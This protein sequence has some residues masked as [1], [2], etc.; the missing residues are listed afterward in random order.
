[1]PYRRG[2]NWMAQI[3]IDGQKLRKTFKTKAEALAWEVHQKEDTGVLLQQSR[4]AKKIV[5]VSLAEWATKYLDFAEVKFSF[6]TYDEKRRVFRLLFKTIDSSLPASS[7]TSSKVL[8]FLQGQLKRRSGYAANR[9]RKNLVAAWNWGIKYLGLPNPNPC[10]VDRFPE[11]R[12][13]R[14]VPPENDFWKVFAQAEN[15][16]D[17]TLLLA[18]LHS[19]ARKSELFHLRWDD[20]DFGESRIRLFTRK[21]RDG[22]LEYDWLPLTDDL[23]N[24]LL[25]LKQISNCEWVFPDPKTGHPYHARFQWIRKLCSMAEVKTFGLHA[26]RHLTASILAKHNVPMIDI[27]AILR[28]KNLSTTERYIRRLADLRP[29]LRVLPGAQKPT[30]PNLAHKKRLAVSG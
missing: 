27:Q 5:T 1:M 10:L 11:V 12:Q 14:Y 19:G 26:I 21:R 29:A 23:Y 30:V 13:P 7:L 6:K 22:S 28:H 2:K 24:A 18:F 4:P 3:R 20:V 8:M 16:Q 17:E 25:E 9:D 15:F